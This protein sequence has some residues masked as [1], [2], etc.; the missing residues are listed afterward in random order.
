MK[1]RIE[2]SS[3][4]KIGFSFS[5][6]A[7]FEKMEAGITETFKIGTDALFTVKKHNEEQYEVKFTPRKVTSN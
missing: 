2:K 6:F 7:D 1:K 4:S 3:Y 5:A